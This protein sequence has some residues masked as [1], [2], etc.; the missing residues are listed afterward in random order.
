MFDI[1]IDYVQLIKNAVS[2]L[3]PEGVLYFSTNFR[4]FK[5]DNETLSEYDV[6]DITSH[7]FI[8]LPSSAKT[9]IIGMQAAWFIYTPPHKTSVAQSTY[10]W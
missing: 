4:R 8:W 2:L 1:Q 10:H 9:E 7:D 3:T 6:H 5:I